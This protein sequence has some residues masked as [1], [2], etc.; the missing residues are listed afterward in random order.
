MRL[1]FDDLSVQISFKP[2]EVEECL[3]KKLKKIEKKYFSY[4]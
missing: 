3:E 4:F 2:E 1:K